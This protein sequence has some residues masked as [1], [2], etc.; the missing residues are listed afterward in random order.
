[1]DKFNAINSELQSKLVQKLNDAEDKGAAIIEVFEELNAASHESLVNEIIEQSRELEAGRTTAAKLGLRTSFSANEKAFYNGIMQAVT[2]TQ[3]DVIPTEIIDRTLEDVRAASDTLSLINMA[4]AGVKKWITASH[5]GAGSWG[6]L[7]DK[8]TAELAAEIKSFDVEACKAYVLLVVPKAIR[9][10]GMAFVDRYFSAILAEAM[11]N[12]L[13]Q[14]YVNGN[15]VNQ[16]IGIMY[17][18]P[19]EEGTVSA[20]DVVATVTGFSP[21]QLAPVKKVLSHKGKRKVAEIHVIA[22]PNTVY[23]YIDPA[24]YV[25][26][27]AGNY[28]STAKDSIIVHEEPNMPEGKAAL[29]IKGAYTMGM[30][31]IR[32]DEYKELK[33]LD[34]CDL[35]IGKC[36]ANGRPDDDDTSF[37]IDATKLVPATLPIA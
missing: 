25:Q 5:S 30:N 8:L 17:K 20:K 10:L 18:L 6:S 23:E 27:I 36:Y 12:V 32:V 29:T 14:G 24:L 2:F 21:K 3:A 9:E 35:F 33:A 26:T 22:N 7:S 15:G 13:V 31:G 4:P 28:V 11:H 16:P 1:M 34:D 37:I 19:N